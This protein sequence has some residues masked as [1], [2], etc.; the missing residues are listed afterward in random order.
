MKRYLRI[1]IV[2]M[3]VLV[4]IS[5]LAI[6]YA[7]EN[8]LPY[9]A[10]RPSRIT[11]EKILK[12]YPAFISP[13]SVGLD[14]S[15]FN[16]TVE[17]TIRLK[18]WFIYARLKPAKGTIF[19]LHGIASCKNA[20][21][22][23]AKILSMEG[24]NCVCYDSRANGESGGL[25]CTFGYFEKKDL[26]KYI[27]STIA[28]FPNSKPYCV[29]GNSLGAA[30][31]IQSMAEDK[32][33][34]CGI[35]ESPFAN[36]RS[37]IHDYFARMFLLRMNFI[38][39]KALKFTEK[40]AHFEIDSVQPAL[41]AKLITNPTMI[42]HG[43]QDEHIASAYGRKVFD[44]ISSKEKFWYPITNGNHYNLSSV[45]NDQYKKRIIEFFNRY[46]TN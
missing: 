30:V 21:L 18:G 27:D 46:L 40:I 31:A 25:N 17:D 2:I 7:I 44:N 22:P 23:L 24:Y 11:K 3:I 34:V 39:D 45:D 6:N 16:I 19:L 26:S 32:R 28:R 14:Y 9:S 36:L 20:M 38:P 5:Y 10:I 37:V 35:A 12:D 4:I 13:I 8:I 29:L 41:S 1:V 43:L 33:L 15:N 42:I